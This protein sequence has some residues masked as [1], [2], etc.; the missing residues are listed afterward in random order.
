[1]SRGSRC[2]RYVIA[3]ALAALAGPSFAPVAVAAPVNDNRAQPFTLTT[4]VR[5]DANNI[6]ATE[7]PG[8]V[9][10]CGG[11][12][13][14]G[15]VWFVWHATQIGD[16]TFDADADLNVSPPDDTVLTV[17]RGA[18]AAPL[19]CNNDAGRPQGPS[20]VKLRVAPGDYLLQVGA[21]SNLGVFGQGA[22]SVTASF[23][24]DL[25]LDGDTW[26]RP[27]DCNDHDPAIHP[28]VV[29]IPDD[30]IDQDCDGRLAINMDRDGDQFSRPKDCR[31]DTAA[32]NPGA[33]DIPGNH[34]DEDCDGEDAPIPAMPSTV[35]AAFGFDGRRLSVVS[36]SVLSVPRN[37]TIVV[38]CQG[39]KR[40][41]IA[42]R[43]RRIKR[44]ASVVDLTRSVRRL[45]LVRG[46]GFEL[47]ATKP[48]YVGQVVQWKAR[49]RLSRGP[50]RRN[51]CLAPGRKQPR[52]C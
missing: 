41:G 11:V 33:V 1:M 47:R 34:V 13:Y 40:C 3:I 2:R 52:R 17:Y 23:Q 20:R 8:E 46:A 9:L 6:D 38:R 28:G 30:A 16:V 18:S 35:T 51:L 36:L 32:V 43:T 39:R 42:S 10:S 24:A 48:G 44:A 4:G 12:A 29:D 50:S 14:K 31:D 21:V 15:T 27:G 45:H 26:P 25:D 7:E 5:A 49:K 19:G 22:V 37:T